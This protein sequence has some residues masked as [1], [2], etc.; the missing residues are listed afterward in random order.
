[1]EIRRESPLPSYRD[2]LIPSQRAALKTASLVAAGL[3]IAFSLLDRALSPHWAGLVAVRFA[4][5]VLLLLCARMAE[6]GRGNPM[7]LA[8][9]AVAIIG[10]TIDAAMFATGGAASPYLFA[11]MLVQAGVSIIIPLRMSQA[12]VLNLEALAIVLLPLALRPVTEANRLMLVVAASYLAAMLV[13]SVAGAAVQDR[14]RRRE[15]QARAEFARHFGLLN[16]GTLAGGL[17]HEL[18]NP[19]NALGLQVEMLSKDPSGVE[20]RVEKLR[21][22]V[23][24]MRNILE[25]MR[26]GARL[27]GGERRQV[28]LAHEVDL[29]FTLM[30]GRLRHRAS[31]VRAYADLPPV[32]CQP[33]LL[34]QVLVNLLSNAADAVSGWPN[35]RIALR[36]RSE[37]GVALIEVEDNG[38]GVP[39]DLAT[40][41]FEPFFSTKGDAG[42]GLGL[43]ISSEIARVHGGT[44][45]VHRGTSGGAL[46]RLALPIDARTTGPFEEPEMRQSAHA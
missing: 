16:L 10:V 5:S 27:T 36:L 12:V 32:F 17:A 13:V 24:R 34:G 38:P 44:L 33:T 18:S 20:R 7:A 45:S 3:V 35:P 1:M 29:A 19:L 11:V 14:L 40:Q 46:F 39:D 30:E 37:D 43:W 8:A 4:A 9:A 2:E 28:E 6:K 25:A 21:G 15:H 31:L 26:N 23:E 41:I 42:N 22:S